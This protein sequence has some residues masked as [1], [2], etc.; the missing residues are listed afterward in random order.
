MPEWAGEQL[1]RKQRHSP[2]RCP[3]LGEI[4]RG[5]FRLESTGSSLAPCF[6]RW[7]A[8]DT[9]QLKCFIHIN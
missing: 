3:V 4:H 2:A 9:Q 8:S 7:T 5:H 6:P 1:A